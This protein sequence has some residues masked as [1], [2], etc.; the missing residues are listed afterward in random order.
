MFDEG[1]LSSE[2][3]DILV[4]VYMNYS[5][6]TGLALKEMTH[7]KG[8]PWDKV[9]EKGENNRISLDLMKA[10]FDADDSFK[11]FDIDESALQVVTSVPE[12]W[13]SPEDRVYD[14]V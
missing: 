14:T 13:D 4:D 5:K 2:E 6:Y 8:T 9:Y 3:L 11:A 10:Y 7:Q 1:R 12:S